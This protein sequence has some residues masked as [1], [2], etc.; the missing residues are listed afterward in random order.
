MNWTN[1]SKFN[2]KC[3][4]AF[5]SAREGVRTATNDGWKVKAALRWRLHVVC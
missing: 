5:R 4:P 2:R 3:E 1:L